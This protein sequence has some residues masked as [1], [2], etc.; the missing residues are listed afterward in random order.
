MGRMVA[1]V[2]GMAATERGSEGFMTAVPVSLERI[3]FYS[4]V[5]TKNIQRGDQFFSPIRGILGRG[6]GRKCEPWWLVGW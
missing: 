5:R 1:S 4:L 2:R 6:R 3:N